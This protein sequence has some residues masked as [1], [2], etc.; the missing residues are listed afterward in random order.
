MCHQVV[1]ND[2]LSGW[3][4]HL[5]E[6]LCTLSSSFL[7]HLIQCRL[8]CIENLWIHFP[9]L[10][11]EAY[12]G[13]SPL[14]KLDGLTSCCLDM[15]LMELSC[16]VWESGGPVWCSTFHFSCGLSISYC[17]VGQYDYAWCWLEI[18]SYLVLTHLKFEIS[19]GRA[20]WEE[21]G[22]QLFKTS[23]YNTGSWHPWIHELKSQPL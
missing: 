23:K 7:K 4:F 16:S 5:E 8:S 9:P 20:I 11:C 6:F 17:L 1:L 13:I 10:C 18:P 2:K 19:G 21:T 3:V 15:F 22:G 14:K 12:L